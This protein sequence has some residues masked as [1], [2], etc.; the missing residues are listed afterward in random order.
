MKFRTQRVSRQ[1]DVSKVK[2]AAQ[3]STLAEIVDTNSRVKDNRM[4]KRDKVRLEARQT[5]ESFREPTHRKLKKEQKAKE[6][7]ELAKRV[8]AK[9]VKLRINAG[10]NDVVTPSSS[11]PSSS[12]VGNKVWSPLLCFKQLLL[13]YSPLLGY[14]N[15]GFQFASSWW[16]R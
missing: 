10:N 12:M 5:V 6:R 3:L 9:S 8:K 14:C 2:M 1:V 13:T 15:F 11:L 4:S 7:E 16:W